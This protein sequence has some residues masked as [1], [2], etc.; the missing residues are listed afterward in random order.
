MQGYRNLEDPLEKA[1][2]L[3]L[4]TDPEIFKRFMALKPFMGVELPDSQKKLSRR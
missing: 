4:L 1:S 3:T 2:G